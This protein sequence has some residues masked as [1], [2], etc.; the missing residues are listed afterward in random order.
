MEEFTAAGTRGW[1]SLHLSTPE[2]GELK[3]EVEFELHSSELT[4]S[5]LVLPR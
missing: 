1:D 2:N 3:E 4:H 5:E